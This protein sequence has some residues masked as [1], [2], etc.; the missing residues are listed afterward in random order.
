M[1][2]RLRIAVSVFFALVAFALS[3]L[4][5]RS[6]WR[7]DRVSIPGWD[8]CPIIIE[9]S[10]G[11]LSAMHFT[12]VEN[13]WK[14]RTRKTNPPDIYSDPKPTWEVLTFDSMTGRTITAVLLPHRF[15]A[16]GFAILSGAAA[17]LSRPSSQ[18]SLRT[19]LIATTLVAIVLGL[20][21]WASR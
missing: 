15:L 17:F 14:W 2:R 10:R 8:A 19:M 1:K 21:V 16:A 9:S 3:V 12:M 4:W 11:Q 5:V 13:R 20:A 18:F 7:S 6:Y